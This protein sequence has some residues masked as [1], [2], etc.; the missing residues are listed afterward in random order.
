MSKTR[1]QLPSSDNALEPRQPVPIARVMRVDEI[2]DDEERSFEA[3]PAER[4]AI[5]GLLDLVALD[6]LSFSGA[7]DRRGQGRFLLRGVLKA[8]LTQTCVVSLVPVASLIDTPV[9]VEFWPAEAVQ[10]LMR[11]AGEAP[12]HGL[13]EWPEPI[14]DGKIDVGPVI[15]ETLSTSLDPYPRAEGADFQWGDEGSAPSADDEPK[16]PFA[17]LASL[18][19]D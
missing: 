17:A 1:R 19:R 13:L 8:T 5:A 15:Y 14:I 16:S 6:R 9:E 3:T 2:K 10:H 12:G 11:Q 7:F 4:D 18:K